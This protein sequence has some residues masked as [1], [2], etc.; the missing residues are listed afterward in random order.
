MPRL[1]TVAELVS[2]CYII[3]LA[4][5]LEVE[6]HRETAKTNAEVAELMKTLPEICSRVEMQKANHITR[7][8]W[9]LDDSDCP[10]PCQ[11]LQPSCRT[12]GNCDPDHTSLEC[13]DGIAALFELHHGS[14]ASTKNSASVLASLTTTEKSDE[15]TSTSTKRNSLETGSLKN[16][17]RAE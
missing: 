14:S 17:D 5:L 9:F 16:R 12:P 15:S 2:L 8:P 3:L 4:I 7:S 11:I 1:S 10:P 6:D 13:D